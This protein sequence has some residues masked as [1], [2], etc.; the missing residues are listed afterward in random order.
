MTQKD[1]EET[2]KEKVT[3]LLEK[4]M[5]HNLGITIPQMEQDITD[6]LTNPLHFYIPFNASFK[7]AKKTF[8]REFLKQEL[9]HHSGNISAL[10]KVLDVDRRS[11][12]RAIKEFK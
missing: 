8:R 3:P 10:A 7:E 12:H 5:Q 9:R 2:I 6:K 4:S 11:I 1:L